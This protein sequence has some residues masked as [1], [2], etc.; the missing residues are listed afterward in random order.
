MIL[1]LFYLNYKLK[2]LY[3]HDSAENHFVHETEKVRKNFELRRIK[4]VE[5]IKK[6][7]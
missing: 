7:N 5:S 3:Y 1:C 4:F 2:I 6:V